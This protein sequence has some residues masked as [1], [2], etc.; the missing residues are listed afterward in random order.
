M[1]FFNNRR[2]VGSQPLSYNGRQQPSGPKSPRR[3]QL[4]KHHPGTAL[5]WRT[6]HGPHS[7]AIAIFFLLLGLIWH[8][9]IQGRG[10]RWTARDGGCLGVVWP[11]CWLAVGRRYEGCF[12]L[13]AAACSLS[14]ALSHGILL[15]VVAPAFFL[16]TCSPDCLFRVGGD[17]SIPDIHNAGDWFICLLMRAAAADWKHSKSDWWR[18]VLC[19]TLVIKR[20]NSKLYGASVEWEGST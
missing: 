5:R 8:A 18:V 10:W 16:I 20:N 13:I 2:L 9:S 7:V 14:L 1:H 6:M 12:V 3:P 11:T 19:A 15:P 17:P 4:W